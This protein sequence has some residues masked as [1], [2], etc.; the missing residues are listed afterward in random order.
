MVALAFDDLWLEVEVKIEPL[1]PLCFVVDPE[2]CS[3]AS[4]T[5]SVRSISGD[6]CVYPVDGMVCK[7]S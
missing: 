7:P 2:P 5:S 1:P 6:E 4:G 3:I